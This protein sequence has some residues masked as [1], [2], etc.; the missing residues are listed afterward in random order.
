[1]LNL[2][3]TSADIVTRTGRA[4]QAAHREFFTPTDHTEIPSHSGLQKGGGR[5]GKRKRNKRRRTTKKSN[6]KRKN[7]KKSLRKRRKNRKQK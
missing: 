7:T 2:F 3:D 6:K 4:L 1:M 5:G